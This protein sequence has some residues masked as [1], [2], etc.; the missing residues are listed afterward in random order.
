MAQY[1]K[2]LIAVTFT[3]NCVINYIQRTHKKTLDSYGET[4]EH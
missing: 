3:Q 4:L 1:Q 2:V